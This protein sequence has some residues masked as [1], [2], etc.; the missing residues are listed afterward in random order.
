MRRAPL[1]DSKPPIGCSFLTTGDDRESTF[2]GMRTRGL[3]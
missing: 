2:A 3:R 1:P